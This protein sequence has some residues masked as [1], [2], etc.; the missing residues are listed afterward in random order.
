MV[1]WSSG[2]CDCFS[3]FSNCC[4]TCWFPCF[5]FGQ[6]SEIVDTGTSS[7]GLN[8]ALYVA[9]AVLIGCPCIYSCAYRTKLRHTYNIDGSPC[10][11]F[12]THWCCSG[13]ALCQEYRELKN[14]RLQFG[15]IYMF[16]VGW[17]GNMERHNGV[18]ATAPPTAYG[19][20]NLKDDP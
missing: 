2:L 7:C 18:A 14:L 5:T 13:C 1:P 20:M 10:C 19:G 8:G 4:M 6:T 17:H 11:D 3:D 15:L 9:I 16:C 12:M